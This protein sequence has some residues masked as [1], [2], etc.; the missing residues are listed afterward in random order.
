M[1]EGPL[2]ALVEP[3]IML[4][5]RLARRAAGTRSPSVDLHVYT[6]CGKVV[7]AGDNREDRGGPGRG[8]TSSGGGY[9]IGGRRRRGGATWK[10]GAP[11]CFGPHPAAVVIRRKL[12]SMI[13]PFDG[14]Y[15]AGSE[16]ADLALRFRWL[17]LK[18]I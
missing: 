7:E 10:L 16:F 12:F 9:P 4:A 14:A 15:G 5:P 3:G 18:A 6:A 2:V 1:C 13:G 17:G 8:S 11:R